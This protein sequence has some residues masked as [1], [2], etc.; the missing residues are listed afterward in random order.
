MPSLP[1]PGVHIVRDAME[2][3]LVLDRHAD[4]L[5]HTLRAKNPETYEHSVRV[6]GIAR[7]LGEHLDI[8]EAE[9][10]PLSTAALLHDIGKITI[11]T[12]ILTK[13]QGLTKNEFYQIKGHARMGQVLLSRFHRFEDIARIVRYHHERW[14]GEGYPD[15]LAGANIPLLARVIH[16][17]DSIDAMLHPRSYK[18]AYPMEWVLGELNRCR[19][20]QFDPHLVDVAAKWLE[21]ETV[22]PLQPAQAA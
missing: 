21:R 7:D 12:H 17:A 6:T 14:D 8:S 20:S 19:G 4:D 15:G 13:A 9:I 1:R 5:L 11:P 3:D 22:T 16:L 18:L 2:L 10:Q